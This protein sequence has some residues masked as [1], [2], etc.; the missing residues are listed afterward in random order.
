MFLGYPFDVC[1]KGAGIVDSTSL[2]HHL[3]N[4]VNS[5]GRGEFL[6]GEVMF[7]DKLSVNAGGIGTRVYQCGGVDDF[8]GVRGGNQLYRDSHR[9]VQGGYKYRGAHY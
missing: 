4:V 2:V 6:S 5:N 8:E 1:V 3:V 9:F 7:S